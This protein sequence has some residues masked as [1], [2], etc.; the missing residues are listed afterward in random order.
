MNEI[1]QYIGILEKHDD[2]IRWED[3]EGFDYEKEQRGFFKAKDRIQ[4]ILRRKLEFKTGSWIQDAS[5]HS[6]LV[7]DKDCIKNESESAQVRFSNFGKLIA[8]ANE[9]SIN[10]RIKID[11]IQHLNEL[12]Y[13]YIPEDILFQPY[14]GKNRGV[15]GIDNW[16]V[17]YFDFV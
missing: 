15:T 11:I 17:R 5:Y 6:H 2:P 4:Q 12:G 3:P 14:T 1:G 10:E 7:L 13:T 16:W 9:D 8:F